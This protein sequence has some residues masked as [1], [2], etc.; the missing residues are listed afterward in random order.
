MNLL[1]LYGVIQFW[2]KIS[3]SKIA[4][5]F[6]GGGIVSNSRFNCRNKQPNGNLLLINNYCS[7][8]L[9]ITGSNIG[10]H[11]PKSRLIVFMNSVIHAVLRTGSFSEIFFSTVKGIVIAMIYFLALLA[12][13]YQP[14]KIKAFSVL[15]IG[16]GIPYI[17]TA[18]TGIPFIAACIVCIRI[19]YDCRFS[20]SELYYNHS[21]IIQN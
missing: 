8:P 7:A 15:E 10:A 6:N 19:I 3:V 4:M 9:V 5:I 20:F 13:E 12:L 21:L 16:S 1:R 11:A 2:N 18:I 17:S 14:M